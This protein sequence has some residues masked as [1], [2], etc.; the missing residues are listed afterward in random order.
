MAPSLCSPLLGNMYLH[1]PSYSPLKSLRVSTSAL[2]LKCSI[3][4]LDQ[5]STFLAFISLDLAAHTTDHSLLMN[6]L[7]MI[8]YL[9]GCFFSSSF[10]LLQ[11][12]LSFLA[13]HTHSLD[14]LDQSH[15]FK[16]HLNAQI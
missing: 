4:C 2:H 5:Y 15:N 14:D 10:S 1:F 9:I 16:Y 11:L 6:F 13:I 12:W 3:S 7:H 8:F